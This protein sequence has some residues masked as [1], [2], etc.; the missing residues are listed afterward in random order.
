MIMGGWFIS[1]I[2]VV[3]LEYFQQNSFRKYSNRTLSIIYKRIVEYQYQKPFSIWLNQNSKESAAETM[4]DLQALVP[5]I[6]GGFFT[7]I[8]HVTILVITVILLFSINWKLTLGISVLIPFFM[9][10]FFLWKSKLK[11][12]YNDYRTENERLIGRM[13]EFLQTI[14]LMHVFN[15][16]S[17]EIKSI[18]KKFNTYLDKQYDYYKLANKRNVYS[19]V[20]SSIAPIYLAFICFIYLYYNLATIGQFF[21]IWGIF[22]MLISAVRGSA[23]LYINFLE[24]NV[25]YE[26]IKDVFDNC[27]NNQI[28][29][30]LKTIK[31]IECDEIVFNYNNHRNTQIRIPSFTMDQGEWVEIRGESGTGKTTL[32]KLIL[33]ILKSPEGKLKINKRTIE[34]INLSEYWNKIGYVE[35][36]GYIYSRSLKANILLGR[37]YHQELWEKVI[38]TARLSNLL[39]SYTDGFEML[40]GENGIQLSGGEKQRILIARALYHEPEWLL[41]DEPFSGIDTKNQWEIKKV[42]DS[43]RGKVTVVIITH[44]SLPFLQFD[45][46]ILLKNN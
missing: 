41:L 34:E 42:L 38:C 39:G 14:P 21:A 27:I 36:D 5:I 31:V 10:N 16:F 17:Y 24:A 19:R 13:V 28:G 26:K 32:L 6:G 35:Q 18:N 37:E 46:T 30:P 45:K 40:L 15:S 2:I 9:L 33:G 8:R 43:L 11:L 3:L 23:S 1:I 7:I 29:E 12:R 25:V 4:N 20:I 44:N 22:A